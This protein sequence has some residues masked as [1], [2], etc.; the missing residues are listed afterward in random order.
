MVTRRSSLG[1]H[2]RHAARDR[3]AARRRLGDHAA[4]RHDRR[5]VRAG[6]LA[7]LHARRTSARAGTSRCCRCSRRRCCCSC[8]PATSCCS[9]WRGRSWGCAAT[10]SSASGT[11]R[12]GRGTASIKAFLTTRVGDVGFAIGLAVMCATDA[13][14]SAFTTVVAARVDRWAPAARDRRRAAA[15]LR[16]DGQ[17][18]AGAAARLAARRDGGPHARLGAHPRRDDGRRGRLPR[19]PRAADL[20]RGRAVGAA[21]RD[22]RRR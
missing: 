1:R 13:A 7:R 2:R 18:G 22:G 10:C 14:R 19:R 16:R 9:T 20:R 5:A 8:S 17:V 15:A 4:R 12:R 3:P 21:R 11:S 6:L